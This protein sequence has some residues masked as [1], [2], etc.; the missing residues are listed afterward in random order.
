MVMNQLENAQIEY[1]NF[2]QKFA[3]IILGTLSSQGIPNASYAP[4]VMD[5][6]KNIYIYVSGL[7]AHTQNIQ[8]HPQVNILFI[9]DE[10]ETNQ[11]FAR[12][13]LS[14]DCT[15]TLIERETQKW[16][17]IVNQFEDRFGQIIEMLRDLRDFRIFQLTPSAGRFVLGFGS[18]YSIR[19]E[20]LNQL[21]PITGGQGG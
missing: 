5:E 10:A 14:F 16:H 7:A 6:D 9:E 8:V 4:F 12:T 2:P 11:I 3:S 15:A 21:I 18:I 1:E 19:G 13:R 17:H 20:N